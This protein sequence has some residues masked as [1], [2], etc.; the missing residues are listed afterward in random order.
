MTANEFKRKKN[1]R[2][3]DTRCCGNCGNERVKIWQD[4]LE[5]RVS[6]GCAANGEAT[7]KVFMTQNW[8]VCDAWK[9]LKEKVNTEENYEHS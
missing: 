6:T 2:K 5:T 3:C 4:G 8:C 9:P 1:W 7:R